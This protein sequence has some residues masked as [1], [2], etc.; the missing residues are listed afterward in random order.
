MSRRVAVARPES[1][2]FALVARI[3][4]VAAAVCGAVV[5]T[6]WSAAA[7]DTDA[8]PWHVTW[9]R[10]LDAGLASPPE[11][12]DALDTL[13]RALA[14]SE[15]HGNGSLRHAISLDAVGRAHLAAG[16]AERAEIAFRTSLPMLRGFLGPGQPRVATTLHDLA[17]ARWK[18]E[19]RDEALEAVDEALAIWRATLGEDHVHAVHSLQLRA[20]LLRETGRAEDADAIEARIASFARSGSGETARR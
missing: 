12:D 18:L 7:D 17:V 1:A 6:S 14:I 3:A 8:T 15:R 9:K 11:S 4:V 5:A 2:G 16:R 13:E 20:H 19:R 10:T